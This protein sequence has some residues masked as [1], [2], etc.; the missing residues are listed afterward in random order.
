[1]GL[2]SLDALIDPFREDGEDPILENVNPMKKSR[3]EKLQFITE[4]MR[5]MMNFL[6]DEG[7]FYSRRKGRRET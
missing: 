5:E 3:A 6:D 4:S 7:I 1:M 2:A